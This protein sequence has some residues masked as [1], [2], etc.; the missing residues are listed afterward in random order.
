MKRLVLFLAL[1]FIMIMAIVNVQGAPGPHGS[2]P[3]QAIGL[4]QDELSYSGASRT[5]SKGYEMSLRKDTRG[6][7]LS[8]E[9]RALQATVKQYY[10]SR[11]ECLR[12]VIPKRKHFYTSLNTR[13]FNQGNKYLSCRS[14]DK[15]GFCRLGNKKIPTENG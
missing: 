5:L 3:G 6:T 4:Q 9:K 14:R 11:H 10:T 8:L 2:P 1:T 7:P 15:P 12:T 13:H